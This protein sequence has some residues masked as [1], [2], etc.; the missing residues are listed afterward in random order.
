MEVKGYVKD[1]DELFDPVVEIMH[2]SQVFVCY[3]IHGFG[4]KH[5]DVEGGEI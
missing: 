4:S 3:C 1:K 2:R 5:Q